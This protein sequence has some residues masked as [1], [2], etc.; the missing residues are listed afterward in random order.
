[1]MNHDSL[2][3][4][5]PLVS[6]VFI[7]SLFLFSGYGKFMQ[8]DGTMQFMASAGLPASAALLWLVIAVELVA[9]LALLIGFKTKWAAKALV[10]Y[11]LLTIFFFHFDLQ[12]VQLF[13]NLAI[14]G[15][16]LMIKLHGPGP[17]SVDERNKKSA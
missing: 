6:R 15:G 12:D 4:W 11:T 8:F 10:L 16:L 5:V 3:K 14:V 2:S 1:M 17:I 7:A 13:K 9:G